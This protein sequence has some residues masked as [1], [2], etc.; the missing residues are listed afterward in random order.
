MI[1]GLDGR[2][3]IPGGDKDLSMISESDNGKVHHLAH[4]ERPAG[5]LRHGST[6]SLTSALDVDGW[7]KLHPSRF[8]PGK[9]NR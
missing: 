3:S 6:R 9:D 4:H 2:G 7:S 5:E 8:T 1:N